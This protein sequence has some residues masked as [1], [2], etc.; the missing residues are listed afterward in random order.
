MIS[1]IVAI[2]A[3]LAASAAFLIPQSTGDDDTILRAM[4]D[5]LERSR[6]LRVIGGGDDLPYFFSYSVTD[7]DTFSVSAAMGA[8]INI[9][10]AHFRVPSIEVRVGSYEFDHTGH[11]FSGYYSGSRYDTDSWPLDDAYSV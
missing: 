2:A 10:H 5:E 3:A 9:G 4:K 11:I 6:Q 1:R 8:P 7:S